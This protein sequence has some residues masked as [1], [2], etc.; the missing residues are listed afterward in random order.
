MLAADLLEVGPLGL[1]GRLAGVC[2]VNLIEQPAVL[3]VQD[4]ADLDG[5]LVP[6]V[7]RA[8]WLRLYFAHCCQ[9]QFNHAR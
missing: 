7:T 5:Y 4:C 3:I 6:R 8:K 1:G 2:V 9:K